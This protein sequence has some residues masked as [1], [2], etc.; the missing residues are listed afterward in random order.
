MLRD[1]ESKVACLT[2]SVMGLEDIPQSEVAS[3]SFFFL[4]S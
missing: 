3:R 4:L 2:A 1:Y